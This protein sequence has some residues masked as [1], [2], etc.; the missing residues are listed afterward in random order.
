M[1]VIGQMTRIEE[2]KKLKEQYSEIRECF[3]GRYAVPNTETFVE[4]YEDIN[5]ELKNF[6]V[7]KC[8][9]CNEITYS[10]VDYTDLLDKAIKRYK[11]T[12]ETI[13]DCNEN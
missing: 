8:L 1:G 6:P 12:S 10:P 13:F 4:E 7:F 11:K 2:L 9:D 3:C 5:L